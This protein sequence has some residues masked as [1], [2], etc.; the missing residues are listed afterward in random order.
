MKGGKEMDLKQKDTLSL[1]EVKVK[2]T[3]VVYI[4]GLTEIL[5]FSSKKEVFT[6]LLNTDRIIALRP[7]V[8]T[9]LVPIDS[10]VSDGELIERVEKDQKYHRLVHTPDHILELY[11]KTT[12]Q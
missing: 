3:E 7:R 4:D 5:P 12:K 9:Y 6:T 10:I 1:V 2:E 8:S 11:N